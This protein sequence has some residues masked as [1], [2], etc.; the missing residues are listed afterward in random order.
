MAASS[1]HAAPTTIPR[2][3]RICSNRRMGGRSRSPS[4]CRTDRA[5]SCS[6]EG[7]CSL[8]AKGTTTDMLTVLTV[9]G[10]RPEAI[11]MAPVLAELGRYPDRVRSRVCSVG[12]HRH[13]LDQVLALFGIV[14]DFE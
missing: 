2:C 10:T 3:S 4:H 14:P 7:R 13:M 11:K 1:A 12:Q 8:H 9:I 6:R 5:C